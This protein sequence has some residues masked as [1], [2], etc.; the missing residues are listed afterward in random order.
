MLNELALVEQALREAG[1]TTPSW[2]ASIRESGHVPTL[3]VGLNEKGHVA[4][5]RPLPAE[6]ESWTVRDGNQNS[7]PFIRLRAPLWTV[8]ADAPGVDTILQSHASS[9]ERR[10]CLLGL[11]KAAAP[12]R[13]AASRWA[14]T[15]FLDVLR[16]RRDQ[17][18]GFALALDAD[19][20]PYWYGI[21]R[22]LK[23][24]DPERG[25]DPS[26]LT[27][28]I[29]YQVMAEIEQTAQD[30]WLGVTCE[31]LV[32]TRRNG[33]MVSN[34][35]LLFDA[36]GCRLPIYHPGVKEA[37]NAALC[38][39]P[40][41]NQG[42]KG[43]C[44]LTGE[45]S[46]LVSRSFRKLKLPILGEMLLYCKNEDIPA[47]RRYGRA[48]AGAMAVGERTDI[49]LQ[50]ALKT[51]VDSKR[52]NI[53]WVSVPSENKAKDDLLLAYV[54]TAPSIG[55]ANL[56]AYDDFSTEET[57]KNSAV[58]VTLFREWTARLLKEVVEGRTHGDPE[59]NRVRIVIVRKVDL[60]N[61]KAVYSGAPTVAD[62]HRAADDWAS[63][64]MNVPPWLALTLART[65]RSSAVPAFLPHVAPMALVRISK[66]WFIHRGA[67][68]R[69]VQKATGLS[70]AEAFEL[71][72]AP[73]V[74]SSSKGSESAHRWIRLLLARR[75]GFLSL[76]AHDLHGARDRPST[77]SLW[78]EVPL[79]V[80]LLGVL[81]HK[82]NR[83]WRVYM[84][85]GAFK[86]GQ[87][88]ALADVVHAGYCADVRKGAMPPSLLGSQVFAMAQT[89]PTLA[90][91]TLC[92]RWK[93]YGAWAKQ[94][95]HK[96]DRSKALVESSDK[97][98][99]ERGWA[100]RRAVRHAREMA[101]IAGDLRLAL[102]DCRPDDVFRAELLL[103][104]IAG[105]PP[106]E[107]DSEN[108]IPR[109]ESID[110]PTNEQEG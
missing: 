61:G 97:I 102:A 13:S 105:L 11:A 68:F 88:L 80:S 109:S 17:V 12:D 52:K 57:A 39:L 59:A 43:H 44:A 20:E 79:T 83:E 10:R 107:K 2:D 71:F 55:A 34:G 90:L 24:C 66:G 30:D 38:Q 37:V 92:R 27:A 5:V 53:T 28:E 23:A 42:R 93:P 47:N 63:G 60:G 78:R 46:E 98:E 48:G 26:R 31:I 101:P 3:V 9:N 22:F 4:L 49:R 81:L 14:S 35:A 91:A 96:L 36:A 7:F 99:R 32:G 87:F 86:L 73:T 76:I 50:A 51:L 67:E 58:S 1:L 69:R 45:P 108:E 95:A 6:I 110:E 65:N 106:A 89:N 104:Y 21:E 16:A 82:L 77:R 25:G 84:N 64:E 19:A 103:G 74:G 8:P 94:V 33:N 41:N 56:I 72:L 62:L 54:E 15:H 100:I 40:S 85:G 70:A 18:R 75:T 29:V